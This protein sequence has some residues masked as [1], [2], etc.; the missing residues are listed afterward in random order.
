MTR[1]PLTPVQDLPVQL[2]RWLYMPAEE[3]LAALC[4][5]AQASGV[6]QHLAPASLA[7][8]IVQ[9]IPTLK[10]SSAGAKYISHSQP[11]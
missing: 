8:M 6:P 2:H 11:L 4:C 9:G 10:G 1:T 7:M 3:M 5:R